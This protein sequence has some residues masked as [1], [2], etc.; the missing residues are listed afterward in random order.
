MVY[1][2]KCLFRT[3]LANRRPQ[4]TDHAVNSLGYAKQRLQAIGHRIDEFWMRRQWLPRGR[5]HAC[6][7]R[8]RKSLRQ[9]ILPHQTRGT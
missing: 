2:A 1:F 4:C 6:D 9:Y 5:D 7:G 3:S 8:M